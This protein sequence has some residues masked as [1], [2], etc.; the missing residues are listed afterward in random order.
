MT[1]DEVEHEAAT[2][3]V[4][5]AKPASQLLLEHQGALCRA[6]KEQGISAWD[7]DA[8]VIQVHG[9]NR[10]DLAPHK[11][12]RCFPPL[13]VGRFAGETH[14]RQ[15]RL[16]EL[17]RHELR[18][19]HGDAEHDGLR[20]AR[21]A[22]QAIPLVHHHASAHVIAREEPVQRR[23]LA[24]AVPLHIREVGLVVAPEVFKRR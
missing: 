19:I 14:D 20:G 6:E 22:G 11:A 1:S 4:V 8:F 10:A 18:V 21:I 16:P 13:C 12:L 2:F 23:R 7:V 15:P 9:D 5:E 3:P 24:G 17:L